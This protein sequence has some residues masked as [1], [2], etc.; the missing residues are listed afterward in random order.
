M[1]ANAKCELRSHL[2]FHHHH[3]PLLDI[4]NELLI[5]SREWIHEK[6]M[7]IIA[8][9][10]QLKFSIHFQEGNP[11]AF[12]MMDEE[13]MHKVNSFAT[14]GNGMMTIMSNNRVRRRRMMM[15]LWRV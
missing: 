13:E 2:Q 3:R 7:I 1:H 15:I 14:V 5:D 4:H 8:P 10:V 11:K 9:V 6:K 12:Y